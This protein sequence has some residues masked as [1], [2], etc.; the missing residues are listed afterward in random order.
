M[1]ILSSWY[2]ILLFEMPAEYIYKCDKCGVELNGKRAFKVVMLTWMTEKLKSGFE[3]RN[4]W[5][6]IPSKGTKY[7]C[8]DCY[9][10]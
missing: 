8:Q 2:V 10:E 3:G 9:Y 6:S 5:K 7:Y 4:Q 1:S